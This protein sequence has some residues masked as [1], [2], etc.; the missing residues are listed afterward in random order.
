MIN[1]HR[2]ELPCSK[3]TGRS[4]PHLVIGL[5]GLRSKQA[6]ENATFFHPAGMPLK[7]P[8]RWESSSF[9]KFPCSG[10]QKD[11]ESC[12]EEKHRHSGESRNPGIW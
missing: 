7:F 11:D 6:T 8:R 2:R 10:D 9:N 12:A 3:R 4:Q 5:C 1:K